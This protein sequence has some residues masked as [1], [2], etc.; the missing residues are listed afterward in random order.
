MT[1][2]DQRWLKSEFQSLHT[3]LSDHKEQT[4]KRIVGAETWIRNVE[5]KTDNNSKFLW[6]IAGGI[7]IISAVLGI[8]ELSIG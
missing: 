5:V 6:M 8:L 7:A 1:E 2:S 4:D 3:A